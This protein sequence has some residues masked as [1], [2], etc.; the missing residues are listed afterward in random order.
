MPNMIVHCSLRYYHYTNSVIVAKQDGRN[1]PTCQAEATN[2]LGGRLMSVNS[3]M[4]PII[5][6][7]NQ[8]QYK[9]RR[10]G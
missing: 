9:R 2:R 1:H 3:R 6:P 5:D 10:S 8:P 4:E 7:T